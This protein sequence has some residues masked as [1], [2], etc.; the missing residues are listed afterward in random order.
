MTNCKY[1][2][3]LI[4]SRFLILP[5]STNI[6]ASGADD[7]VKPRPRPLEQVKQPK[8]MQ[9]A[10]SYVNP[11]LVPTDDLH[12]IAEGKKPLGQT[13]SRARRRFLL[14]I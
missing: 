5:E 14:A 6:M 2:S 8:L 13:P 9:L 3:C 7:A 1:L 4:L 12:S 10:K 11:L